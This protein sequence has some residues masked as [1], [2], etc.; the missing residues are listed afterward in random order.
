MKPFVD[1]T[2]KKIGR[3]TVGKW[4]MIGRFRYYACKCDCGENRSVEASNLRRGQSSCGCLTSEKS[5]Q[6]IRHGD[7]AGGHITA[8][9]ISWMSMKA[10][11]LNPNHPNFKRYGG[12]GIKICRRWMVYKNFLADM[13]RKP[14]PKHSLDRYPNN[15]GNYEPNNCRWATAVE[16]QNNTSV[17]RNFT[18]NGKTQSLSQ[19]SKEIGMYHH[20]LVKRIVAGWTFE[21]A[22]T[23]PVKRYNYGSN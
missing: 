13:G 3:L 23:T 14:T 17:N 18:F 4:R 7:C 15:N 9:R 21:K 1:L 11:C 2:G 6:R 12:R 8:E 19:W 22:I 5:R 20:T 10:R 16:Q